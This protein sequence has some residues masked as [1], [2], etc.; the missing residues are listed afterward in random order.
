MNR[1]HQPVLHQQ[2]WAGGQKEISM[3]M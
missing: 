2:N 3:C 1:A